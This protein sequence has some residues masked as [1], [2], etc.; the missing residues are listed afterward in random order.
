MTSHCVCV[1][2]CVTLS[3][4]YLVNLI[5]SERKTVFFLYVLYQVLDKSCWKQQW[6]DGRMNEQ[7]CPKQNSQ[8]ILIIMHGLWEDLNLRLLNGHLPK[9][10]GRNLFTLQERDKG[11]N[12][13]R[14]K[15]KWDTEREKP[16]AALEPL[17]PATPE[18]S[19]SPGR[20]AN[21]YFFLTQ[22]TWEGHPVPCR[23]GPWFTHLPIQPT[24][25]SNTWKHKALMRPVSRFTDHWKGVSLAQ[26]SGGRPHSV[27]KH[28]ILSWL[29]S[30][31]TPYKG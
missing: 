26:A 11:A 23:H 6:I 18:V 14:N 31:S 19:H 13:S 8:W 12:R 21:K 2:L 10:H 1:C 29:S 24:N 28:K 25:I 15:Q 30:H 17:H 16:L 5:R 20:W 27:Y 4:Y 9:S 22:L 7:L 3:L